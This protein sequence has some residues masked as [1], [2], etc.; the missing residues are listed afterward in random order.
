MN[1]LS[2]LCSSGTAT[3][4]ILK[5][6]TLLL[7]SQFFIKN[8]EEVPTFILALLNYIPTFDFILSHM[9]FF[10]FLEFALLRN[11]STSELILLEDYKSEPLSSVLLL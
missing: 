2:G 1:Q 7:N 10:C 6:V 8:S 3:V 11:P 4:Q 5:G 9:L